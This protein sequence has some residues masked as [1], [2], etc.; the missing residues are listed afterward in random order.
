VAGSAGIAEAVF[1][2]NWWLVIQVHSFGLW[3]SVKVGL[4]GVVDC[5]KTKD[6]GVTESLE[7]QCIGCPSCEVFV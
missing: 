3:E 4:T 5:R 1:T 7:V 2:R 6:F